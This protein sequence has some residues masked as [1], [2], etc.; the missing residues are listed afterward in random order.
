M[1]LSCILHISDEILEF[2]TK[3]E[4]F[5]IFL[6]EKIRIPRRQNW[7]LKIYKKKDRRRLADVLNF[8]HF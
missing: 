7:R 8:V 1:S 5:V 2:L 3:Y 4:E 6:I